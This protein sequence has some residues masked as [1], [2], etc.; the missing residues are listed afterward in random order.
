MTGVQTCALPICVF[1]FGKQ[2]FVFEKIF[3]KWSK[4]FVL[5]SKKGGVEDLKDFMP[6]S[7][8]GG[9]YKLL[10]FSVG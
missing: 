10:A 9:L 1:E 6:I 4:F 8:V 7:L 3:Q 2:F 5:I